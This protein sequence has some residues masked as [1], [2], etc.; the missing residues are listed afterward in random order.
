MK[1]LLSMMFLASFNVYSAT[2]PD[3]SGSFICT[4]G[5]QISYKDI[6]K[7]DTGFVII[8]DGAEME[9]FTDKKVYTLPDNENIRNAKVSTY[10]EKNK[11]IVDFSVIILY[12]GSDLAKQVSKTHYSLTNNGMTISQKIK[13]KGLPMPSLVF[14]C[15][16]N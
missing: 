6:H 4:K 10:C 14:E 12:E 1:L 15:I 9:Y 7:T 3:I 11:M 13:M 5:S 2:C 16:K 8:S